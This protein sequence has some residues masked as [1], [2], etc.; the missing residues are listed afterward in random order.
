MKRQGDNKQPIINIGKLELHN[1][2]LENVQ[3]VIGDNNASTL[4][5]TKCSNKKKKSCICFKLKEMLAKF[6][7]EIDVNIIATLFAMV[8]TQIW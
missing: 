7:T 6:L 5:T 3:F 2:S 4:K 8:F 1:C